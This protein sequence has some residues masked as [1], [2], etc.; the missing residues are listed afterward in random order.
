M[1]MM[2]M[3]H[4]N[5]EQI[6]INPKSHLCSEATTARA[7][8]QGSEF[9][10]FEICCRAR[11]QHSDGCVLNL[12]FLSS[13]IKRFLFRNESACNR[14]CNSLLKRQ[15]FPINLRRHIKSQVRAITPGCA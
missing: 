8:H 14:P 7:V 15:P 5:A 11:V 13:I 9:T 4:A 2:F 1:P 10:W 3:Y 12:Y 6:V